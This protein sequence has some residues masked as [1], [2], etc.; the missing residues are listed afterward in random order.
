MNV[1]G[2]GKA[3]RFVALG[4]QFSG[5]VLGGLVVGYYA[6]VALGTSPLMLTVVTV[7]AFAGAVYRLLLVLRRTQDEKRSGGGARGS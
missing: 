7:L 4:F 2:L 3:G 6:D 1:S 5:S